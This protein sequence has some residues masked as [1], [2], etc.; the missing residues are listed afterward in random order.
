[1]ST[2]IFEE[3]GI[4]IYDAKDSLDA[5]QQAGLDWKVEKR[6]LYYEK[7]TVYDELY[8]QYN[9]N[10][11]PEYQ[12]NFRTD[13][14]QFLGIST[15]RYNILQNREAFSILDNLKDFNFIKGGITTKGKKVYL[16]GD[17]NNDF[18]IDGQTDKVKLYYTFIHG[19]DGKNGI[20]FLISPM[21]V[22][23]INQLNYNLNRTDFKFT[24]SHTGNIASKMQ[25]LV[26]LTNQA[27]QYTAE[28]QQEI[29][30]QL[31]NKITF[32]IENMLSNHLFKI[33]DEDSKKV[34]EDKEQ[35]VI[36]ILN[37]YNNKPDLQNYKGTEFGILS[38]IS[39][40]TSH[41]Q[42]LRETKTYYDTALIKMLEGSDTIEQ[43]RKYIA[44]AA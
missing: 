9:Y 18:Y 15:N 16:I 39:D 40:Y 23:C 38:A 6:D 44:N 17:S 8:S 27:H 11:I 28:L 3:A 42:P 29:Q 30:R 26:L 41:K 37:L 19:H 25:T 13:T 33:K 36:S 21:R 20:K 4:E 34:I 35:A 22:V 7:H 14:N 1:M 32:D 2:A 12:G 43:A 5:L 31:S 10:K 24:F